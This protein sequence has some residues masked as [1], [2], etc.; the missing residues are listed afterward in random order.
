MRFSDVAG[1]LGGVPVD[2]ANGGGAL[3]LQPGVL[4]VLLNPELEVGSCCGQLAVRLLYPVQDLA[5]QILGLCQ[6]WQKCFIL[7]VSLILEWGEFLVG[8][9]ASPLI[10]DLEHWNEVG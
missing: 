9:E 5:K 3:Q 1:L 4:V 2:G 6:L 10:I 8:S 7:T